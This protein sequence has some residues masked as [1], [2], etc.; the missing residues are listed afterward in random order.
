VGASGDTAGIEES[1]MNALT[2]ATTSIIS[3]NHGRPLDRNCSFAGRSPRT[4]APAG[5][6]RWPLPAFAAREHQRDR[7][8]S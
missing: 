4:L 8:V 1:Q 3:A 2:I 6:G 5:Q 7:T